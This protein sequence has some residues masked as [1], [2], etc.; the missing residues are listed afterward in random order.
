MKY[1]ILCIF[2][3]ISS[4]TA[5]SDELVGY[6]ELFIWTNAN[7]PYTYSLTAQ[8]PRWQVNSGNPITFSATANYSYAFYQ[9]RSDYSGTFSEG[10][11]F[12]ADQSGTGSD[13]FA[14][15]VYKFQSTE[16]GSDYYFYL[17]YRD[18]RI[19]G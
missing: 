10:F 6:A 3:L 16:S 2:I 8:S 17:D 15:G 19:I 12:Q 5:F 9:P 1:F 11:V 4:G 14:Y 13:M 18:N 7:S